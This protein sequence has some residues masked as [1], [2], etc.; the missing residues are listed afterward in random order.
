M[1]SRRRTGGEDVR[2]PDITRRS[3]IS[4]A[5]AAPVLANTGEPAAAEDDLIVR[6]ASFVA[7]D[8]RVGRLVRRWGDLES[9]AFKLPGWLKLSKDEQLAL[10]QGREMADIDRM[11]SSLFEQRMKL[12]EE[13]PGITAND[14][15][16]VAA[17]IAVAARAVD[18]EDHEEAHHLIAGAA[19]DLAAMRCP[20]CRRPLVLET[21]IDWSIRTGRG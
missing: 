9:E 5:T 20:D 1:G 12:L 16:G 11:L 8:I 3:V 4:A 7:I 6:C 19:R 14:P 13:L 17:K 15:T 21:W 18:P 10:P 2:L